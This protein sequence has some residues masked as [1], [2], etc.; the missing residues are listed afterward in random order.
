MAACLTPEQ[1]LMGIAEHCQTEGLPPAQQRANARHAGLMGITSQKKNGCKLTGAKS[2]L[3][4]GFI[5]I[6]TGDMV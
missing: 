5:E 2:V 4:N 1:S 6:L 3:K